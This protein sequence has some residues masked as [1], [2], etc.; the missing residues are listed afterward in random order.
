METGVLLQQMAINKDKAH[1][2]IAFHSFICYC[3]L[4]G[5]FSVSDD[6]SHGINTS[7]YLCL[8]LVHVMKQ[9]LLELVSQQ[10]ALENRSLENYKGL[11]N[12]KEKHKTFLP[13]P[14]KWVVGLIR[15]LCLGLDQAAG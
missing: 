2:N 3:K 10:A 5:Q 8:I 12:L 13:E 1:C 6:S 7:K 4:A 15:N 9:V 11:D 14:V